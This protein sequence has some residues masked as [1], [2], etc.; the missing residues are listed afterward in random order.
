MA[1]LNHEPFMHLFTLLPASSSNERQQEYCTTLAMNARNADLHSIHLLSDRSSDEMVSM[2]SA[3][4]LKG[5]RRARLRPIILHADIPMTYAELL[6][7]ASINVTRS[8]LHIVANSDLVLGQWSVAGDMQSCLWRLYQRN[9]VFALSRWEPKVCIPLDDGKPREQQSNSAPD[10]GTYR[11]ICA[12]DLWARRSRDAIAFNRP[13][14]S[15][16]LRFLQF[17]PNRLGAENLLSCVLAAHGYFVYNPCREL[18]LFHNHC[19]DVRTYDQTRID[20]NFTMIEGSLQ[21]RA[22]LP[23]IDGGWIK[24]RIRGEPPDP[25]KNNLTKVRWCRGHM[26][27]PVRL[28]DTRVCGDLFVP[29]LNITHSWV[30]ADPKALQ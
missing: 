15:H 7:V 22:S 26:S 28:S 30:P 18:P 12:D 6:R 17:P 19:S 3:C 11:S 25:R 14:K 13:I 21:N 27:E 5:A 23:L 16:T 24:R 9:L 1:Q 29:K 8:R 4:R 20:N 10:K 2:L